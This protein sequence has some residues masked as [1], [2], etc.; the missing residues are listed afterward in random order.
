MS[1]DIEL[2][3]NELYHPSSP[4]GNDGSSMSERKTFSYNPSTKVFSP[5]GSRP[6]KP[7]VFSIFRGSL[8]EVYALDRIAD[9]VQQENDLYINGKN[10]VTLSPET[11]SKM[12]YDTASDYLQQIHLE[13]SLMKKGFRGLKLW[14]CRFFVLDK[15]VLVYYNVPNEQQQNDS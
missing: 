2:N 10:I 13:G 4:L 15:N 11:I 14:K 1:F 9:Y 6:S 8:G 3:D 5:K 12:D 7:T